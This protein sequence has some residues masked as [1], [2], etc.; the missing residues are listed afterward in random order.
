MAELKSARTRSRE[1]EARLDPLTVEIQALRLKLQGVL[2]AAAR[3]AESGSAAPGSAA[4]AVDV[5]AAV[6]ATADRVAALYTEQVASLQAEVGRG[7]QELLAVKD[8]LQ[9][10]LRE[11][12]FIE[13]RFLRSLEEP[14]PQV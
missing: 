3:S 2:D 10:T 8:E 14:Q 13:D 4:P 12:S 7:A 5:T 6:H 1:L 11:K 9:R